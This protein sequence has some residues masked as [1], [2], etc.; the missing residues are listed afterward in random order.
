M[1]LAAVVRSYV[2]D[3]DPLGELRNAFLQRFKRDVDALEKLRE[4]WDA[5]TDTSARLAEIRCIAHGLSG[6]GGIFGFPE[7]SAAA[8]A[9]EDAVI[10]ELENPGSGAPI[11]SAYDRLMSQNG[12]P[13]A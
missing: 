3:I 11:S 7:I 8:A 2:A 5:G 1:T 12:S 13:Y 9:L 6:A 10:V 4:P